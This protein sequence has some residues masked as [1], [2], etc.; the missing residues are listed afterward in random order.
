MVSTAA[1]RCCLSRSQAATTW[2][3]DCSRKDL[4]LAGPIIPQPIT[5]MVMRS[6]A[7]GRPPQAQVVRG[8]VTAAA[9]AAAINFLRLNGMREKEFM[10][11]NLQV[12]YDQPLYAALACLTRSP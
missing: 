5:P 2:Q 12:G 1:W 10:K 9:P 8:R 4:V 11:K 7:G 6:E 3:S